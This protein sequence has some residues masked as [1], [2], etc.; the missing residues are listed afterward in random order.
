M[1][2]DLTGSAQDSVALAPRR[3]GHEASFESALYAALDLGTN[4]CRMLIATPEHGHFRVVDAFAK[5]VRLGSGLER[6]GHLSRGAIGRTLAALGVTAPHGI[7]AI[8]PTYLERFRPRGQFA[9]Y[10]T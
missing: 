4:S 2:Q 1:A 9:H 8:V 7:A 6:T 5:S 10:R 3:R